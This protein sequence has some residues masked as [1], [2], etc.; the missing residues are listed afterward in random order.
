MTAKQLYD[1]VKELYSSCPEAE[2]WFDLKSLMGEMWLKYGRQPLSHVFEPDL[3]V[4]FADEFLSDVKK[5]LTGYPLQYI[6]GKAPFWDSEFYVG[7]GVLI[8]RSDTERTV[9][10]ALERI[11]HGGIVYDLCCGSGCIGISVVRSRKDIKAC[12]CFD[13]SDTALE[14]TRKNAGL[15]GVADRIHV[16]KYD[17][18]SDDFPHDIPRPDVV[19]SNPPYIRDDEMDTLPKNVKYEPEIALAGGKDGFDFYR[20]I[21]NNFSPMLNDGGHL[22]FEIAH[23]QWEILSPL[24]ISAGFSPEAFRDYHGSI[25]TIC[26]KI[27]KKY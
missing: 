23:E 25:R 13:I 21:I 17:V 26:G 27:E 6:T 9:E 24:F 19:V 2:G 7:E 15:N 16:I 10:L 11:P 12:Y 22:L 18:M 8:P 20:R 1:S 3:K 14:Y 5:A 4:D